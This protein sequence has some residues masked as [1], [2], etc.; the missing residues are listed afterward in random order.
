[1]IKTKL[2]SISKNDYF[3]IAVQLR[4][5]K[6]WPI[7]ALTLLLVIYFFNRYGEDT[8]A[9]FFVIYGIILIPGMIAYLYYWTHSNE[10]KIVFL[11]RQLAFDEEKISATVEGAISEIPIKF[12]TKIVRL[13]NFW[14][15]YIS[16]S[17]FVFIPKDAFETDS[18]KDEFEKWLGKIS[19][20]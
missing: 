8:F 9:T 5:R 18:D 3:K 4:L 10:N 13:K 12:I 20:Q 16:K 14:L 2:Y 15:I 11:P 19:K 1:M 6:S 17:Q 7:Y